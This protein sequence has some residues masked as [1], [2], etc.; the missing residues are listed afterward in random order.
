MIQPVKALCAADDE[1]TVL[2]EY[3]AQLGHHILFCDIVEIYH[4]VS[5]EYNVIGF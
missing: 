3:A 2:S 1:M 4:Y 5:T